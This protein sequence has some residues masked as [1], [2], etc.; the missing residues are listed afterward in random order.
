YLG[1][2]VV[3]GTATPEILEKTGFAEGDRV[4]HPVFGQGSIVGVD[5]LLQ[6]Y[7]IK[8]DGLK[9]TRMIVFRAKLKKVE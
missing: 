5:M 3:S 8:F 9:D 4:E 6:S 7:E 1:A 2:K